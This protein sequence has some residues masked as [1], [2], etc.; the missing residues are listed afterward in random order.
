MLMRMTVLET[1][2]LG[3]SK[4]RR[5]GKGAEAAVSFNLPNKKAIMVNRPS[6]VFDTG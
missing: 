2:F 5:D 4:C 3:F 6:R 1:G